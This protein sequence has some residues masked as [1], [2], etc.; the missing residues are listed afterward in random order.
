MKGGI[1]AGYDAEIIKVSGE[2]LTGRSTHRGCVWEGDKS[3]MAWR[4]TQPRGM[5]R[6]ASEQ[7]LFVPSPT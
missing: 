4:N 5:P 3:N 7:A 1:A 2:W 6:T